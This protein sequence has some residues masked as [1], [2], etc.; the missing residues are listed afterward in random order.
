MKIRRHLQNV[1]YMICALSLLGGTFSAQIAQGATYYVAL[2]GDDSNSGT[3]TDPFKAIGRAVRVLTPG[4]TLYVREGT[5]RESLMD[6]IPSGTSWDAPVT[7]AAFPGEAVTIQPDRGSDRVLH[8]QGADTHYIIVDGFILDAV[9]VSY[10]AIKITY[11]NDPYTD[12][13][14]SIRIKNSEIKNG[15]SNGLLVTADGNE[16]INLRV[17]DNGMNLHEHGIYI[18]SADNLIEECE[19]Y[20]NAGWGVHVYDEGANKGKVSDNIVRNSKIHNN[21]ESGTGQGIVLGSG[22]GNKAYNNEV[23]ENIDGGIGIDYGASNTEVYDNEVYRNG[24]C[25]ICIGS[26]SSGALIEN[27]DVYDNDGQ[28]ITDN[29]SGTKIIP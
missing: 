23:W 12:E 2:D 21:G 5:Y 29:G 17:H 4:D 3:E 19:I 18:A 25:G 9:N 7:V 16:F 8:F 10:D 11:G 22:S 26:G 1:S 13:A 15:P 14:H 28:A 24:E 20:N 6:I 27:N